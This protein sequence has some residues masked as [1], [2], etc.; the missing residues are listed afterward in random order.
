MRLDD[1][2]KQKFPELYV[3]GDIMTKSWLPLEAN[4]EVLT[5]YAQKL[6]LPLSIEFHDI[7]GTED[8]ALEMLPSPLYAV[9]L[10]FP[11]SEA[12]ENE[13]RSTSVETS[14]LCSYYMTQKVGNACGTVAVLHSLLNIY[15]NKQ[16]DFV[17]DSYV[18]RM[19][20]ATLSLNS[21]E[22]GKWLEMNQE[23]ES[24][25]LFTESMGQSVTPTDTDT[26]VDTHFVTFLLGS[27]N[28]TVFE[29][30]GRRSGPVNRGVCTSS[31]DFG[32]HV[33]QIIKT[34]FIDKNSNDIRFSL[35]G[36]A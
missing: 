24:A 34:E 22:R 21:E 17:S 18:S 8:W 3:S 6:G 13:R 27:D 36:L 23:I 2:L 31:S 26:E 20:S 12:S 16:I 1:M 30:D 28:K 5:T 25:H 33:L 19:Y 14:G 9:V 32:S 29:L 15:A 35:L 10:L 7:L 4:P 11:I